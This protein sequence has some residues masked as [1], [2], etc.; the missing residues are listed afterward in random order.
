MLVLTAMDILYSAFIKCFSLIIN[1]DPYLIEVT[2]VTIML[3]ALSTLASFI[4]GVPAGLFIS[5][6]NFYGKRFITAAIN[7]G[8][9]LP[10]VVVGL[11]VAILFG[12]SGMFGDLN[13]LYTKTAIFISQLIIAIPVACGLTIAA[14][15]EV[16]ESLKLQLDSFGANLFQKSGYI[17]REIKKSLLVIAMAAFGSVVS[18]VGAVIMVGGNIL[19]ETRVLTTAIVSEVRVGN[20]DTALGF[21]IILLTLTFSVNYAISL[22]TMQ[23]NK[24]S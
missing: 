8:M 23:K 24:N 22:L 3:S 6:S 5:L 10:P 11:A 20:Y 7:A 19:N 12:R 17:A 1:L 18:E 13:L 21:A 14:C 2:K 4:I 16:P 9:G 15:A